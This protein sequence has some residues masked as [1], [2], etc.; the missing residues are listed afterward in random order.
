[1]TPMPSAKEAIELLRELVSTIPLEFTGKAKVLLAKIDQEEKDQQ[2][3]QLY[4]R[5]ARNFYTGQDDID[6]DDDEWLIVSESDSGAYV[7]AWVWV[8]RE[9]AKEFR[10]D[11]IKE[12]IF[13]WKHCCDDDCRSFGCKERFNR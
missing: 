1:M 11:E 5:A 4:V 6:L 13:N 8:N 2:K 3:L 12:M 9:D 10:R 7:S